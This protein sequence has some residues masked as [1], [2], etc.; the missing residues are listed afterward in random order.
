[1]LIIGV[2][3]EWAG[4]DAAGVEV[5]RRLAA[6]APADMRVVRHDGGDLSMLLDEWGDADAAVVVDAARSGAPAG[7]VHRFDAA[8]APLPAHLL[9]TSTHAFGVAETIELARALGR[10]PPVLDVYA[11][12]GAVFEAGAPLSPVVERAVERVVAELREA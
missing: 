3:N 7:A 9:R 6:D 4:D 8:C 2:G 1:M 5:A 12:E 11:I 10:L